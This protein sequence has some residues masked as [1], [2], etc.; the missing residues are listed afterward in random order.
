VT[1]SFLHQVQLV[2]Q[3][4]SH[5]LIVRVCLSQK[6]GFGNNRVRVCGSCGAPCGQSCCSHRLKTRSMAKPY[7]RAPLPM[8]W[9]CNSRCLRQMHKNTRTHEQKKAQ[10]PCS[11]VHSPTLRPI[12]WGPL[13]HCC[14]CSRTF[15]ASGKD[16]EGN[17]HWFWVKHNNTG[18]DTFTSSSQH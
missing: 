2:G 14:L 15:S 11:R 5:A 12:S 9:S 16:R 13:G 17:C 8:S 7:T 10:M 6:C 18:V 3:C 4:L 1:S